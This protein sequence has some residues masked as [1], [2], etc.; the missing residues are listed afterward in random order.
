MQ[1]QA[2]TVDAY[3]A[4]LPDDRRTALSTLRALIKKIAPTATESMMYG[5]PGFSLGQD[6]LCGLAS[7]KHYMALYICDGT[8][9][10]YRADL[11]KL[12]CG[13][14]CIRF[15]KWEDLPLGAIKGI[16]Q[17]TAKLRLAGK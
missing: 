17:D 16:L 7:Q 6:T 9:D 3:L 10:K 14:G 12:N 2:K 11:G 5:M 15:R 13:K 1:S 8:V 4:E